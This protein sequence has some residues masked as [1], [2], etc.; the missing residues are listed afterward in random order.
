MPCAHAIAAI[1]TITSDLTSFIASCFYVDAF[2]RT[3]AHCLQP[4]NGMDCWPISPR[5]RPEA[6]GYVKIPGRPRTERR[7]EET[8]KKVSKTRLPKTG[9]L[10][11]CG[12]CKGVGHNRTTCHRQPGGQQWTTK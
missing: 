7:K 8:E 12:K 2:K 9:T 11:R 5:P 3:Y 6:P 10:I 1:H 4:V